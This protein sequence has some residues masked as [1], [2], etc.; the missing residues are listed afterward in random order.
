[1]NP[2]SRLNWKSI[3]A[4]IIVVLALWSFGTYNSLVTSNESV[5]TAWR[6]VETQYQRRFDLI[7]NL[8]N[9]VKGS[10][11]FEQGT[12][13]AVTEARTQWLSA[14]QTQDRAQQINAL[15]QTQS[16]L[17]RLLATVEA[18][19]TLRS[20]EA[21]RDLMVQLE[22]TENRVS[23]ARLD[24]NESVQKY[25]LIVKRFPGMILASMFGFEPKEG[26]QS[27]DGA[28]LAPAVE[29]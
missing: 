4:I 10:A 2:L 1:M 23:V 5:E 24:Y 16:A 14:T 28:E 12:L 7:P 29:F 27:V 6:H 11:A 8:V 13:T 26:F 19:P 9:T 22:G 20:T 25:N 3:T 18:Y 15:E 17:S 21:F